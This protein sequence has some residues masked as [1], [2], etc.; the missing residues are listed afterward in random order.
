MIFELVD[1]RRGAAE[2]GEERDDVLAMLL[3]ARHEDS[4]PMSD[5]EI[6]DELMTALV[7]GH[8]TTASQLAWAFERL[9]REPQVT[10]TPRRGARRRTTATS[11]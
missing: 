11:T 4:S 8:E 6:R 2:S 5:Q 3:A 10:A 9:S 1:E 7:A